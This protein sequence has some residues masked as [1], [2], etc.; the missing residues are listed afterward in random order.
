MSKPKFTITDLFGNKIPFNKQ[1]PLNYGF[2]GPIQVQTTPTRTSLSLETQ[3][4]KLLLS[5]QPKQATHVQFTAA[6]ITVAKHTFNNKTKSY[7][8]KHPKQNA[9]GQYTVSEPIPI[10][11]K[12]T[13]LQMHLE[14]PITEPLAN[15]TALMVALGITFGTLENKQFIDLLTGKAMNIV[16]IV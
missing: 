4:A 14:L 2:Q 6:C 12:A 1:K 3:V 10:S 15:T 7:T 5:G 16:K 8:P 9:L 11:T 13:D